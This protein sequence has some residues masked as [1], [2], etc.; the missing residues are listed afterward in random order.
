MHEIVELMS[1]EEF[2]EF[3]E[4]AKNDMP[5]K[6]ENGAAGYMTRVTWLIGLITA[7]AGKWDERHF[8]EMHLKKIF[9]LAN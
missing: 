5:G 8:S 7:N 4:L 9:E 1:D 6:D 2:E 3:L